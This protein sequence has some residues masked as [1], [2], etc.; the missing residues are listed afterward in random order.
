MTGHWRPDSRPM[1]IESHYVEAA[2]LRLHYR[3]CG[4]GEPVLLL[5]GW[6]TSSYLWREVIPAIAAAG[7]RAIALDLPGFG[8]SD[9]PL[10]ASYSF[11]FFMR[12]LE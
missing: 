9:K 7:S 5:H 1:T 2:G 8:A 4:E 11:H 12:A 10:D 3:S 6:P